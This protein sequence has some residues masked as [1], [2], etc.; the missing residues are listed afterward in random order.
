MALRA[1]PADLVGLLDEGL[2]ALEIR[3]PDRRH[4]AALLADL[5][6]LLSRWSARIS[7]TGHRGPEAIARRLVLDAAAL[8]SVLPA[9]DTLAD[10]G[11]GAGFPGLPLAI[12]RPET[13]VTLVEARLRRHHFQRE[14]AR[15]LGLGNVC[16]KLGRAEELTPTP[17]QLVV[18]QA[19]AR[20]ERALRWMRRWVAPGG[21]LALP[22][23]AGAAPPSPPTG[24]VPLGVRSY[25][26]PLGGPDRA[27]WLARAPTPGRPAADCGRTP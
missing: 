18:A 7:L 17:H 5:S 23:A 26:V 9:A 16:P 22:M 8:G 3:G 20:P 27:V 10:L 24:V 12:L 14:A 13:R 15:A 21:H 25:R 2:A 4:T 1:D 11:S 19:M 6:L